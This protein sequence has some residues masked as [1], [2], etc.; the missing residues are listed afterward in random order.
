MRTLLLALV[1]MAASF[2]QPAPDVHTY[3]GKFERVV[4]VRM[5]Y[6]TDL[7]A[8]L[9]KA[10]E[11]EGIRNAV[12]LSAHGS[13]TRYHLHV[14]ENAKLPPKDVF[15]KGEGGWDVVGASGHI[16]NGRVHCHM[17]LSTPD[18][19]IGGHL[20]P[21]TNA[22]TFVAVALGVLDEKTNLDKLDDWNWR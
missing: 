9:Q 20:E 13:V 21:G 16:I 5:K 22:F 7:L 18:K 12:I 1:T 8:G 15:F 14:V 19:T 2:A 10:V 17:V 3:S 6:G 4:I 11:R